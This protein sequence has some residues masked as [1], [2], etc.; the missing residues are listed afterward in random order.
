M[1]RTATSPLVT[2]GSAAMRRALAVLVGALAVAAGAQVTLPLLGTSVPFTLQVPVVLMVGASLGPR[3]GAA[4]MVAYLAM[5]VAGLPVFAPG[6]LPG[7]ARLFGPTGGYL[8]AFPLAAAV[9]GVLV[10]DCR[11]WQ[12]IA[13]GLM[14]GLAAVHLGGMAQL[15]AIGNGDWAV[16]AR[17]GS[18]PFL[19]L[20]AVKLFLA[21]LLVRRFAPA[22]RAR[23]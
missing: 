22:L 10:G 9:T 19:L 23:L 16:A 5:G 7:A 12:R 6:G 2:V 4:S 21:L 13:V 20:D 14:A 8:L 1:N 11:R 15:A 3:L 18:A 17:L